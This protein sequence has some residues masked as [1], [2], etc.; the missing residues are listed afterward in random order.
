MVSVNLGRRR[1]HLGAKAANVL[2]DPL[3][4]L[5]GRTRHRIGQRHPRQIVKPHLPPSRRG[6]QKHRHILIELDG[7]GKLVPE[8][9]A[10]IPENFALYRRLVFG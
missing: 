2:A 7:Q 4:P 5:G 9:R 6:P 10:V 8:K 3:G 1:V